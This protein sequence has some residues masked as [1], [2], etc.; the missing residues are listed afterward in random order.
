MN[1]D[2]VYR[3]RTPGRGRPYSA[4]QALDQGLFQPTRSDAFLTAANKHLCC[5]VAIDYN[6]RAPGFLDDLPGAL[7]AVLAEVDDVRPSEQAGW[8][9]HSCACWPSV[10]NTSPSF[11]TGAK[12]CS[13]RS[14]N[15]G[16]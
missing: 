2:G 13:A 7:R 8:M 6:G 1:A 4:Q 15:K 14:A 11:M 12:S 16:S 3:R 10:L 5:T 9:T